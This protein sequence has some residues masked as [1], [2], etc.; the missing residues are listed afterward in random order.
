VRAELRDTGEPLP[1]ITPSR[2]GAALHYRG[3][4]W[5]GRVEVRRT[6][7]QDRVAALERP[8][9]GY[10]FLNASLGYR[11]FSGRTVVDLLLR[12]TNLTDAE[13]RNHVSFLKDLVP[14]PGRDVRLGVRVAF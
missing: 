4:R 5:N 12:G 7:A 14:L 8:T 11:F 2:V 3:Q 1:R 9:D 10:T 13:G 6:A